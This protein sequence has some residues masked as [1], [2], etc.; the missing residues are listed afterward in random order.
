MPS[1]SW[2]GSFREGQW[3]AFRKFMLEERRDANARFAYIMTELERIG[4]VE[5][6]WNSELGPD[7]VIAE[8]TERR[9]G[10][11]VTEDSSLEK[12]LAAYCATGGNPFDISMFLS[13]DS[14]FFTDENLLGTQPGGGV[15]F[16][17]DTS[18]T[19]TSENTTGR[20]SLLK[21]DL[22]RVGGGNEEQDSDDGDTIIRGRKWVRQEINHKR[23]RLEQRILKLCDLRD[24]LLEE[25]G[26]IVWGCGP[27]VRLPEPWDE[28]KYTTSLTAARIAYRFDA[29]FRVPEI[30]VESKFVPTGAEPNTS[31]LAQ[32][33]NLFLDDPDESNTA[34]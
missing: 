32:H 27:T 15:L 4:A 11:S 26:D 6:S 31:G 21:Y 14:Q 8:V 22:T 10:M 7:G 34:F 17:K 20:T 23:W 3:V 16:Y 25:L 19:Y 9:L 28:S 33:K 5:I 18:Y 2:T 13:P 12:L 30:T 1:F 29:I 24:Q